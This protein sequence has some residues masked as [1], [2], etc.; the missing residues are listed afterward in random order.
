MFPH[1]HLL[2]GVTYYRREATL[3]YAQILRTEGNVLLD[4][5]GNQLIIGRLKHHSNSTTHFSRGRGIGS[6]PLVNGYR[7]ITRL[8]DTVQVERERG[9]AGPVRSENCDVLSRFHGEINTPECVNGVPVLQGIGVMEVPYFQERQNFSRV[10]S[11]E[12]F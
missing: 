1:A 12:E 9:L 3:R 8:Q 2:E 4:N 11:L 7:A 6:V 5:G 10:T